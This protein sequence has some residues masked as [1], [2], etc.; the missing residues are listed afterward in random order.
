[1]TSTTRTAF[2]A[3]Y[4]TLALIGSVGPGIFLAQWLLGPEASLAG[5]FRLAL[6]NHVATALTADLLISSLV[7]WLLAWTELRR[8]NR[9]A[10]WMGLL[11]AANLCVGLSLALPLFL[12]LRSHWLQA[13]IPPRP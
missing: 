6:V 12:Y 13:G 5:F 4:L 8:L 2:P 7:F 9:P 3:L 11:I 1:M 10:S